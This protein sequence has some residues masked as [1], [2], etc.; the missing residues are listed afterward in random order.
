MRESSGWREEG[1]WIGKATWHD[2]AMDGFFFGLF[3]I[4]VI[5]TLCNLCQHANMAGAV[6]VTVITVYDL[7]AETGGGLAVVGIG[8]R[9]DGEEEKEEEAQSNR[10]AS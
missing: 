7:E 1:V 8:G 10:D 5:I 2:H 6:A 9:R 4:T 3:T